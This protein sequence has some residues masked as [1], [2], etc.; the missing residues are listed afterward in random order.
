MISDGNAI[1][2]G[3][4]DTHQNHSQ[5]GNGIS[6]GV[7]WRRPQT[8]TSQHKRRKPQD[9]TPATVQQKQKNK[10]TNTN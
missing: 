8:V 9:Q 5:V 7:L 1:E 2:E 4:E 3:R 10:K 6:G